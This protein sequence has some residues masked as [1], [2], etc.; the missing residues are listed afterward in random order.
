MSAVSAAENEPDQI[1]GEYS[2]SG[3]IFTKLSFSDPCPGLLHCQLWRIFSPSSLKLFNPPIAS[4]DKSWVS[5]TPQ[6]WPGISTKDES[7][8]LCSTWPAQL[9]QSH[10]YKAETK[11][12]SKLDPLAQGVD[13]VIGGQKNDESL[14]R[15]SGYFWK[16]LSFSDY[17]SSWR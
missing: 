11:L 3:S 12:L 15:T 8:Y 14:F 9:T 5:Q 10:V 6:A 16:V 7:V 13:I 2:L 1:S 17:N 4:P